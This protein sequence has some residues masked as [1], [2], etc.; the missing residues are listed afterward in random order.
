MPEYFETLSKSGQNLEIAKLLNVDRYTN[1]DGHR[2]YDGLDY[3]NDLNAMHIAETSLTKDQASRY[4][5][6]LGVIWMKSKGC[7]D[8]TECHYVWRATASQRALAFWTVMT[9]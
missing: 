1:L 9:E 6:V 7:D 2:Y 4:D 8:A 3:V 5:Y